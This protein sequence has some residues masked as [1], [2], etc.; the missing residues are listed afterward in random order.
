M[1]RCIQPITWLLR[2]TRGG[3]GPWI[4]WPLHS[5]TR[6]LNYLVQNCIRLEP[7]PFSTRPL[8]FL[9]QNVG[10]FTTLTCNWPGR[11][12]PGS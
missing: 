10:P 12:E 11:R 4:W 2:A 7:D 9:V 3:N 6:S 8:D 5:P 1:H